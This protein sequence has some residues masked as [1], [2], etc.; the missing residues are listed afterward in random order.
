MSSSRPPTT[1]AVSAADRAS[2]LTDST[3]VLVYRDRIVPRSEAHFLRRQYVGFRHLV[4]IW[5]GC[6]TDAGLPDLGTN[7]ILLGRPGA[8]GVIDRMM[9]KQLGR[10]PPVPD[11]TGLRPRL[12]HAH[13]GRGGALALPIARAL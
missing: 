7:P 3:A 1:A 12:I 13:F 9:F 10:L 8:A 2:P 6:R 4:P 11:L 5:I